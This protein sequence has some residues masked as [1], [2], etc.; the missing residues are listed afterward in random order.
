MSD[1]SVRI[2]RP[3]LS[4]A[5]LEL[6]VS[7]KQT[8]TLDGMKLSLRRAEDDV[9]EQIEMNFRRQSF[10]LDAPRQEVY[11]KQMKLEASD[12]QPDF[13]EGLIKQ[14][15]KALGNNKSAAE[16]TQ[17]LLRQLISGSPISPRSNSQKEVAEF[18][19]ALHRLDAALQGSDDDFIGWL[20]PLDQKTPDLATLAKKLQ[21][22]AGDEKQMHALLAD[23][24]G[25]P[26]DEKETAKRFSTACFDIDK[27]R[28][29]LRNM[30]QLPQLDEKLKRQLSEHLKDEIKEIHRQHGTHL[31]ALRNLLEKAGDLASLDLA[32][33]YDQLVHG[34]I[35]GFAATMEI[36]VSRH[37]ENELLNTIIPVIEKTLSHELSLGDDQRSVDKEKLHAILSEIQHMNILKA[38]IERLGI[39]VSSLGRM[40]G[41]SAA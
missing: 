39:F 37:T 33:S 35:S 28:E 29:E 16:L 23:F 9:D 6:S 8:G 26:D 24:K 25:L 34:N 31:S 38:L 1:Q 3:S 4:S 15:L 30:Q 19:I 10:G 32:E 14:Y 36:L 2:A 13:N 11:L 21:E 5:R 27:L 18:A 20:S 7:D 12:R 17:T 41:I 22:S 40:Y